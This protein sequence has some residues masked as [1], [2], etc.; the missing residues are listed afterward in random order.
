MAGVPV[1]DKS[2]RKRKINSVW[3]IRTVA[4]LATLLCEIA[5]SL[6]NNPKPS[7]VLVQIP[8]SISTST[9]TPPVVQ[10]VV[11]PQAAAP[12][13]E[14][15]IKQT[16]TPPG[17]AVETICPLG[18]IRSIERNSSGVY[19]ETN[20]GWFNVYDDYRNIHELPIQVGQKFSALRLK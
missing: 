16:T 15:V 13:V 6:I 12:V 4:G 1:E 2:P 9:S 11:E 5:L 14:P 7:P 8:V 19:I 20:L 18:V 17:C 10:P 3:L